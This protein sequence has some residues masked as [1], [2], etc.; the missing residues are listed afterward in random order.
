[1]SQAA[2]TLAQVQRLP[3]PLAVSVLPAR[4]PCLCQCLSIRLTMPVLQPRPSNQVPLLVVFSQLTLL[5]VCALELAREHSI[6]VMVPQGANGTEQK[7]AA[8][9]ALGLGLRPALLCSGA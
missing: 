6:V 3:L 7:T 9:E 8:L 2:A 4:L 5:V 1:M